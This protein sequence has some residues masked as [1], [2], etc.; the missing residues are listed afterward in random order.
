MAR[1]GRPKLAQVKEVFPVRLPEDRRR[2]LQAEAEMRDSTTSDVIRMHLER[3]AEITWRD[4]PKLNATAWCAVFEALGGVPM[5]VG[6]VAWIG[7]S[8]ARLLEETD[9]PEKWSVDASEI[10]SAA[11]AWTFGQACAVADAMARF[12][13]ALAV[14]GTDAMEAARQAT[15]RPAALVLETPSRRENPSQRRSR[16]RR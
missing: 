1:V 14:K 8:I 5:D 9:L 10:A 7:T 16:S 15:T 3:Y 11:R 13:R 4:L 2:A 12:R 6:T